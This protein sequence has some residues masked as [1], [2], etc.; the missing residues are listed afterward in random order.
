MAGAD[1]KKAVVLLAFGTIGS[2]DDIEPFLKNILKGRP[3]TPGAVSAARK[4]Y[5]KIGGLSPLLDITR[6]QA[7]AL[8][9]ALRVSD[10]DLRVYTAMRFWHPYIN[11]TIREMWADGVEEAAAVIMTPH[12]SAASTGGYRYDIEAA[13]KSTAGVPEISYVE[14]WH[15]HPLYIETL[16]DN[17]GEALGTLPAGSDILT[18]FS[19]HSLPV[20]TL[21]GDPY[22][23]KI[24]RTA[25]AVVA[26][27]PAIGEYDFRVAYQSSG[28]RPGGN[29]EWL[30]PDVESVIRD[31]KALG[32]SGVLVVPISFVS[33]H[34]ETLYDIDI[35][36]KEAALAEGLTFARAASI[37]TGEKFIRMLAGLVKDV[38]QYPRRV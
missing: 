4:R 2:I 21:S 9:E 34:I 23:D 6:A 32:K 19:A 33:D 12:P 31:A 11:E 10:L 7:G 17:I 26:K 16:A 14:D 28:G 20:A 25:R 37:N 30:G 15:T 18:I 5:L 8:E 27:V 29:I 3:V 38:W 1:N 35:V 36:F 24:S 22:T 13:L